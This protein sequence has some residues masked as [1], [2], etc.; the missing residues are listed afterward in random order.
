MQL[1][2]GLDIGYG[3][4][5]I[6]WS[7]DL[8]P[9]QT[10]VHPSG[11]A[12]LEFCARAGLQA[13][14]HGSIGYG[15]EVVVNGE[16]YASLIDPDKISNGMPTLHADYSTTPQYMALYLGALS[17]LQ[18]TEVD[19]LV[20]G[21]PV[22]QTRN[23]ERAKQ[24][25]AMLEGVHHIRPGLSVT[26]KRVTV[27]PQA[28]GAFY[29][30]L[31][32]RPPGISQ[33]DTM[34]VV[35]FGH[36]S[37]DWVLVSDGDFRPEF[38]GSSTRGGSFVIDTIVRLIEER[39]KTAV[40]RERV[41]S[42]LRKGVETVQLGH[43]EVDLSK[44]RTL[45]SRQVAPQVMGEIL[46]TIRGQT[47]EVNRVLGCGGGLPFYMGDVREYFPR[48]KV[49]ELQSPVLANALGFRIFARVRRA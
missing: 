15:E 11:A 27:V 16:R 5:K 9:A 3:Q 19:H 22:A 30:Y 33:L 2:V 41:Y 34:M 32:R 38:S 35:D 18:A 44:L 17:R 8:A 40:S 6:A 37:V 39:H 23:A 14:S 48:A 12:P 49:D 1:Q 31:D 29:S 45:A 43:E 26:V 28:I 36:Y 42:W 21:L 20:T 4:T 25:K 46:S 24:V 10:E 7:K 13:S 47:N